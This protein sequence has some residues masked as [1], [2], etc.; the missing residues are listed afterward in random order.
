MSDTLGAVAIILAIIAG[1]FGFS[2]WFV[3]FIFPWMPW[4]LVAAI[5]YIDTCM[6]VEKLVLQIADAAR[7]QREAAARVD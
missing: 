5:S 4:Y 6:A 1:I 7:E 2:Y 3:S